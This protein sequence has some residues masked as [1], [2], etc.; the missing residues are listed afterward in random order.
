[1]VIKRVIVF[2][3]GLCKCPRKKVTLEEAVEST[4]R[5]KLKKAE[6]KAAALRATYATP[7]S[8]ALRGATAALNG[9]RIY[10]VGT[11]FAMRA[12]QHVYDEMCLTTV[13]STAHAS[14]KPD[15]LVFAEAD[16]VFDDVPVRACRGCGRSATLPMLTL[17]LPRP[18]YSQGVL[19][20]L[21]FFWESAKEHKQMRERLLPEL[22]EGV[23]I[24]KRKCAEGFKERLRSWYLAASELGD[25]DTRLAEP[26]PWEGFTFAPDRDYS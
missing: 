9:E 17:V 16:G 14:L 15:Y 8:A 7:F 22:P 23:V 24:P 21:P 26:E 25:L 1:M 12:Q 20:V 19:F 3:R 11:T 5:P 18:S 2:L 4:A 13:L 10:L 6:A